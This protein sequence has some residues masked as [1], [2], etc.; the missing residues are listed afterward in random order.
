MAQ[1]QFAGPEYVTE[2]DPEKFLRELAAQGKAQEETQGESREK[3]GDA[4]QGG[5]VERTE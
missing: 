5:A 2:F 3:T 4:E 1:E